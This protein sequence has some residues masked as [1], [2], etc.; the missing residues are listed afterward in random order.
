[1]ELCIEDMRD[2]TKRLNAVGDILSIKVLD[3]HVRCRWLLPMLGG[4]M[5]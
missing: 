1:M 5:C 4:G 2:V 3:L